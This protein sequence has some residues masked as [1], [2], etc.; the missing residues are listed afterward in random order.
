MKFTLQSVEGFDNKF[1]LEIEGIENV[2]DALNMKRA[3]C[4][5]AVEYVRKLGGA[6]N[7]GISSYGNES[8][9]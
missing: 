7:N 9:A 1:T 5:S 3:I 8:V 4:R 6:T 2:S